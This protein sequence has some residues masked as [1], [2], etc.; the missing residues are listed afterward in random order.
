MRNKV[1]FSFGGGVQSTAIA[2]RLIHEPEAFED[3]GLPELIIFADTGAESPQTYQHVNLIFEKLQSAGYQV[4]T[5]KAKRKDGDD[6]SI[7]DDPEGTR[8]GITTP[9]YYTKDVEGFKG[10]LWRQCTQEYKINPIQ[11]RIRF[12]LG[13]A[14][15]KV[16][17]RKSTN[18]WLGISVDE[19]HRMKDNPDKWLINTYPLIEWNWDRSKCSDYCLKVLGYT[20][21]KS[22]CYFCP[23]THKNEW[24][25]RKQL[26]PENFQLAVKFDERI[27]NIPQFGNIKQPCYIHPSCL[28]LSEVVGDQML[29]PLGKEYEFAEEC[30]GH[31][32]V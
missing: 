25:R 9:P 7:L 2:L 20:V 32:G 19:C 28:P 6:S 14:P 23:F 26:E 13:Y 31:C 15:K 3:L 12:E 29:L 24:I 18:L 8:L 10:I 11:K 4:A 5:V 27:R 22:A 17:P 21:P 16:I 30:T 1:F